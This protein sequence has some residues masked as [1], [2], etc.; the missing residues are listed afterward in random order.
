MAESAIFWLLFNFITIAI[1]AFFSMEEMA[2]VSFNKIRLQFLV[3][4][5]SQ[6]ANLLNY[7]LQN[8]SRLFGT[9]LIG[10]NVATIVGSECSRQFHQAINLNPDWAPLS[11]IILV[12][13]F[14]ELAPMFAARRYPEHVA[15]LGGSIIYL[16]SKLLAPV[17]WI[18]GIISKAANFIVGGKEPHPELFLTQDE[19]QKF[20]VDQEED[21]DSADLNI[22]ATNIFR[23]RDKTAKHV[24]LPLSKHPLVS[25]QLSIEKLRKLSTTLPSYLLVYH[26]ELTNIIGIVFIE[27]LIRAND[28][29]K[30]KDFCTSPWFLSEKTPLFQILK[31]FRRNSEHVAIVLDERGK[32][33]GILNFNDILEEIFG[34]T[35]T[36]SKVSQNHVVIDRTL[37]ASMTIADFNLEFGASL[38]GESEESLS[39]M[40][41]RLLE[42]HPEIGETVLLP[43]FEFTIKEITLLEVKTVTVKTKSGTHYSSK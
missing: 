3:K 29:H 41:T 20:I 38:A 35:K 6:R 40:L 26:R 1:L 27:D 28:S 8:P 14:G 11:Q 31:Q 17:I 36:Y 5:G 25:S 7:L 4:Q 22:I 15:L 16:F 13:I 39:Q 33:K 24:M 43:P 12:I 9:T 37:P 2:L 32:A 30:I 10:V 34:E 18:L 23:L 19:L 42:H 21:L